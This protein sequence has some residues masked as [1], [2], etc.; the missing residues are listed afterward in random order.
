MDKPTW[1]E[2]NS[3]PVIVTDDSGNIIRVNSLFEQAFTWDGADLKGQPVS[4]IIPP[5]LRDAHNMGF[6]RYL[7]SKKAT[8]LNMPLDL[9]IL[10]GSGEVV[11]ARHY[12]VAV[13]DGD[14]VLFAARIETRQGQ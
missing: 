8:L 9:E 7:L 14:D 11:L 10:K 4:S 1:L 12:I 13:E 2:D 3:V 5:N 6:S